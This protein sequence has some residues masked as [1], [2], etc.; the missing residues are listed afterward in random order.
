[1]SSS[2]ISKNNQTTI[3]KEVRDKLGLRPGDRIN[4]ELVDDLVIL[5]AAPSILDLAGIFKI[6]ED[7]K[8]VPF[9]KVREEARKEWVKQAMK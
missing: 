5:K 7:K 4:Y 1:M 6:P 8:N 9:K 3:P 2:T